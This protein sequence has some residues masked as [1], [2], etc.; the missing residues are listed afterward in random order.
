MT[1]TKSEEPKKEKTNAELELEAKQRKPNKVEANTARLQGKN[2][3]PQK[4]QFFNPVEGLD[5]SEVVE[6]LDLLETKVALS[7]AHGVKRLLVTREVLS[8]ILKQN[9]KDDMDMF[10]KGVHLIDE[11]RVDDVAKK[12]GLSINDKLF[13]NSKV[14]IGNQAVVSRGK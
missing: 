1:P 14:G 4:A 2:Q 5:E 8:Q 10:Y 12:M 7:H 11:S 3:T 6:S 13:G 9:Y